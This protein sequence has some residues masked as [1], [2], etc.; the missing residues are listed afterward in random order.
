[1][2]LGLDQPGLGKLIH[3]WMMLS[4]ARVVGREGF[5]GHVTREVAELNRDGSRRINVRLKSNLPWPAVKEIS[6]ANVV[7][8]R[9][10]IEDAVHAILQGC[11][12][13]KSMSRES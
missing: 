11:E 4:F 2:H 6:A 1:M 9:R 5:S 8:H 7:G 10:V 13:R 3:R 12:L